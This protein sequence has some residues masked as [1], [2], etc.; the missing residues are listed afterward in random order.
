MERNTKPSRLPLVAVAILGGV[1]GGLFHF[2]VLPT[3]R[4][5]IY[6]Q[7][8]AILGGAFVFTGLV[9]SLKEMGNTGFRGLLSLGK[10]AGRGMGQGVVF[11]AVHGGVIAAIWLLLQALAVIVFTAAYLVIYATWE[12]SGFWSW[13]SQWGRDPGEITTALAVDFWH[14]ALYPWGFYTLI[15]AAIGVALGATLGL[16]W[17]DDLEMDRFWDG[18]LDLTSAY[19][20]RYLHRRPRDTG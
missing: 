7:V 9:T 12:P 5:Q 13:I 14:C 17:R 11:G 8:A 18:V 20:R 16:I 3:W 4:D 2:H 6:L 19:R 1:M 10:S 15:G